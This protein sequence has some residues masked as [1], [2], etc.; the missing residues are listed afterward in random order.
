[1]NFRRRICRF[2]TGPFFL[3]K[4]QPEHFTQKLSIDRRFECYQTLV[5]LYISQ[6][7]HSF[8]TWQGWAMDLKE[9][10]RSWIVFDLHLHFI[11]FT[12]TFM[13]SRNK[14]VIHQIGSWLHGCLLKGILPL[15]K[16]RACIFSCLILVSSLPEHI[17]T[18]HSTMQ[19]HQSSTKKVPME[20]A[21]SRLF[22][23]CL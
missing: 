4:K 19:T 17:H 7:Y 13:R 10:A 23:S 22:F 21:G 5:T 12:P 11:H 14:D 8:Q 6:I 18:Q 16:T 2:S 3:S 1:M 20:H 15:R 9:S